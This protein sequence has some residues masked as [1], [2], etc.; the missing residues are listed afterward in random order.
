MVAT[1]VLPKKPNIYVH[2]KI[3]FEFLVNNKHYENN[4]FLIFMETK[5]VNI[6]LF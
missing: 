1:K 3:C 4:E 2:N 6:I 5:Q